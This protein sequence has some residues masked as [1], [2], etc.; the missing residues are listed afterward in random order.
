MTMKL[1]KEEMRLMREVTAVHR[2][3]LVGVINPDVYQIEDQNRMEL[4]RAAIDELQ[5]SGFGPD[6]EPNERGRALEAL[7]GKLNQPNLDD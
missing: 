5:S 7:I 1:T 3:E 4:M 2:P 6:W